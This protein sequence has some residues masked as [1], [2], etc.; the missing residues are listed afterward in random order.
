MQ[1]LQRIITFVLF[2][3]W[4][5]ATLHSDLEAAGI[6][7]IFGGHDPSSLAREHSDCAHDRADDEVQH[8]T[9]GVSYRLDSLDLKMPLP[10]FAFLAPVGAIPLF[11][12][13]DLLAKFAAE[14][15]AAPPEVARTWHFL[16]RAAP[17]PRAPSLVV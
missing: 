7:Y 1:R 12:P 17:P 15:G 9:D 13:I 16:R 10:A 6:N 3:L 8:S 14:T 2:A 11:A 4:L 5:P